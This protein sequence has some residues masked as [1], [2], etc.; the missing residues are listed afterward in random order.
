MKTSTTEIK[1]D[2]LQKWFENHPQNY[3]ST[4]AK[5]FNCDKN[6]I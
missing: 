3:F 2:S 1:K 5:S 4:L 6:R